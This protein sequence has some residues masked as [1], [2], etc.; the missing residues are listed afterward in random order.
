MR[1][2]NLM[3]ELNACE[4]VLGTGGPEKGRGKKKNQ[5]A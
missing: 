2:E 5:E 1:W 3:I 4:Y